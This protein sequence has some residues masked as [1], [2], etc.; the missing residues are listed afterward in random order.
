MTKTLGLAL[1]TGGAR[2]WAHVGVI[3]AFEEAGIKVDYL[4]GTSIGALVGAIYMVGK[5]DQLETFAQEASFSEL[6]PL[7]DISFPGVG[8]LQGDR[9]YRFIADYVADHWLEDAPI[10]FHCVATN[11]LQKQEVII[12]GGPMVQAVR[13]SI[14]IPG[15]FAPFKHQE[16]VYLVDGGIINPLPISVV[17]AMGADVVVAVNLNSDTTID[18]EDIITQ[19][20]AAHS[21]ENHQSE[22]KPVNDAQ[23]AVDSKSTEAADS[24]AL[25]TLANR[26]E[27]LKGVLN[28]QL[29]NWI[30]DAETG[31]NIFDV[32]GNSINVME[33]RVTEINLLV[34]K[35][36]VLID[37]PL[38]EFGTFD[39]HQAQTIMPRGYE[40]AKAM[41][42]SIQALL[43]D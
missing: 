37:P 42:P 15:I 22:P 14:S 32:L 16:N 38:S 19:S 17:R 20:P 23:S 2:G 34:D 10:P 29:D 30:P 28:D 21:A 5:L 43:Q 26:Y 12:D 11:F 39:F 8:L 24:A 27:A 31:I 18:H 4:A 33:K 13:A 6:V 3:R 40:A 7:M 36:D 35:P 25:A 1:G 41:I 9:V